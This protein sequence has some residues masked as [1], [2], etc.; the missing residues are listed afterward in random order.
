MWNAGL[1]HVEVNCIHQVNEPR[2]PPILGKN[3]TMVDM[4]LRAR[5]EDESDMVL[6]DEDV[7]LEFFKKAQASTE[8]RAVQVVNAFDKIEYEGE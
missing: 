2:G 4:L 7:T 3:N 8:E 1:S 5:Y 6:K